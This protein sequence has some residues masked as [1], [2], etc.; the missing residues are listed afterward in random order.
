[1]KRFHTTHRRKGL[2]LIEITMS[3][4][5]VAILCTGLIMCGESAWR[6]AEYIRITTE[7]RSLARQV[8]ENA[9]A[10]GRTQLAQGH[11]VLNLQTNLSTLSVPILSWGQVYWH[12]SNGQA[13]SAGTNDYA[14]VHVYASFLNPLNRT[15][16]TNSLVEIVR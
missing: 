8:A 5:L 2:T 10:A 15:Y 1:M 16:K 4:A 9:R 14:E 12:Q 6:F 3:A 7:A 11:T 13:A